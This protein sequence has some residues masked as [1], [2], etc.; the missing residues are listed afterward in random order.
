M[1]L[2]EMMTQVWEGMGNSILIF[3]LTLVFRC[4]WG[5]WWPLAA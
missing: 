5:F 4:R 2:L 1:N 3:V